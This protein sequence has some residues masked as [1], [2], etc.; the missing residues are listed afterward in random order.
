M[1]TAYHAAIVMDHGAIESYH[2]VIES[3]H[4]AIV[5]YP[6]AIVM[7]HV[8]I[9]MYHV[10]IVMYPGAIVMYPAGVEENPAAIL[11]YPELSEWAE[12]SAKFHG[13]SEKNWTN[14]PGY[15]P[16]IRNRNIDFDSAVK[17]GFLNAGFVP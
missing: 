1:A 10:A 11:K 17:P 5:M 3:Y 6:G 9:V 15:S 7:Y 12:H 14:V 4:A 2:R 16:G 8:A 13:S